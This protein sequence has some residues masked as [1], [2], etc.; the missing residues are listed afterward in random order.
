MT[1]WTQIASADSPTSGAFTFTGL[2]LGSYIALQVVCINLVVDTDGTSIAL[3]FYV[4][5]TEQT[6]SYRWSSQGMGHISG[7]ASGTDSGNA[8]ATGILL[9]PSTAGWTVGNAAGEHF[10]ALIDIDNPNS[11]LHKRA[12]VTSCYINV[13]SDESMSFG[14][15][16]L[17]NTGAID[18]IKVYPTANNISTG[19]VRILGL[20]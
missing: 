4:S 3:R 11:S 1:T 20:A 10:N 9:H 5:A 15:G 19:Q 16:L 18:G 12:I 13:G 2:S 14:A 7:V 8:A 6:T 17:E